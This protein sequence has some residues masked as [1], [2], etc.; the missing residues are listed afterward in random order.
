MSKRIVV[1]TDI[2]GPREVIVDGKTG[3]LLP[4]DSATFFRKIVELDEL[5]KHTPKTFA[6]IGQAG[7]K[8][9]REKFSEDAVLAS[10][11]R[12]IRRL[13]TV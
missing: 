8:Y 5:R 10:F 13:A 7:H 12:E 3:F 6:A 9:V 1:S 11:H 2:A 4:P